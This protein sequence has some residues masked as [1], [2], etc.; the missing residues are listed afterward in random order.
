MTT[1]SIVEDDL[2]FCLILNRELAKAG[3]IKVLST[4]AR[5]EEALRKLPDHSPDVVLMDIKLPGMNGIECLRRLRQLSPPLRSAAMVLT[6]FE[7]S[8]LVFEALKA[9]ARGYVLKDQ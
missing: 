6:E 2:T 3:D 9:G 5:A 1:V 4:H 8:A 7:D